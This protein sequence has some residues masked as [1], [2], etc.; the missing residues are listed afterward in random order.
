MTRADDA[1]LRWCAAFAAILVDETRMSTA[2]ALFLAEQARVCFPGLPP[3]YAVRMALTNSHIPAT[4]VVAGRRWRGRPGQAS[5]W[6]D[7][8]SVGW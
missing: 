4:K 7:E 3:S 2:D 5:L 6:N 1:R 8:S